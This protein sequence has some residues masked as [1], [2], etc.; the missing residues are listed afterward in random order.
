MFQPLLRYRYSGSASDPDLSGQLPPITGVK[1]A[2]DI[3]KV[4]LKSGS[5]FN[6]VASP[7]KI[8]DVLRRYFSESP[9][10]CLPLTDF[11]ATQPKDKES[12]VSYWVRLNSAAER[13]N[14]YLQ[15]N[16]GGM[17]NMDAEI[18]MMFIQNCPS[19]DLSSV[20]KCK[21][22]TKWSF[23][24]GQEAIDEH[25]RENQSCKAPRML[26]PHMLQIATAA[27]AVS[28]EET[29]RVPHL[30]LDAVFYVQRDNDI[31]DYHS[32]V[33][34]MRADLRETVALA[35]VNA[36]VNFLPLDMD[37]E[38]ES[39]FSDSDS[40]HEQA[41]GSFGHPIAPGSDPDKDEWTAS[42]VAT[43]AGVSTSPESLNV[44]ESEQMEQ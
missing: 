39:C 30:P 7:G 23:E 44:L 22:M 1:Q 5:S 2:K 9:V 10:S 31:T 32:Y 4:G 41:E 37:T 28:P 14:N 17:E 18:A 11:Y 15:C 38:A 42:W 26:R 35:Q 40:S 43:L 33:R 27:A 6:T 24:E 12:P 16:G 19:S 8:Y 25:Q 34:N 36:N 21:P 3:V 29:L 20:F 13:A